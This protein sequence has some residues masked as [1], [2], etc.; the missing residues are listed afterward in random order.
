MSRRPGTPRLL[1]QLNDR[2]ALELLLTSGPLTRTQLGRETGLSK[3]TASQLLSRLEE[4]GLVRVAGSKAGGRGPNA[5][6]YEAVPSAAYAVALEVGAAEATAAVA[7]ITGTVVEQGSVDP[8]TA[9]DPVGAVCGLVA[10]LVESAGVPPERLNACVIGT[11]GVVDPRTGAV[12]FSFDLH[13]WLEGVFDALGTELGRPV[14]IEND[15]NLAAMA[16]HAEGAARD[17][18]DFA[19][20]WLS[21]GVGMAIMLDGRIRSGR[22]GGAGE[23]G[24]LPVPGA[25]LPREVGRPGGF[26]SLRLQDGGIDHGFQSLVGGREIVALAGEHGITGADS[27]AG[28]AEVIAAARASAAEEPEGTGAAFLDELAD[29]IARGVASVCVVLDP[30]LVV[31]GG[32]VARAGGEELAR[33]V[34]ESVPA[35]GPNAPEVGVGRVEEPVLRGA[36]LL[37]L[38][39]AR[40]EL[41]A[42]VAE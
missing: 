32:E 17:E 36:L 22:S 42:A 29:R 19:L 12:R 38:E 1:R 14:L 21:G 6:L 4:R 2:A 34:A 27:G 39:N 28:A 35:I 41:Y 20:M 25:P 24:Y 7:D 5:A 3:V 31:L 30:G 26:A 9:S 16:E 8:S 13:A 10:K 33:R 18:R 37:A 23:I 40:E 11:P 15:V